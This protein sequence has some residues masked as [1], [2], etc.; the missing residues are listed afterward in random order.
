[1][2][3]SV[4]VL[5]V[6]A[7]TGYLF[8][9]N[10]RVNQTSTVSSD[11]A[12]L[13]E[14]RVKQ[15]N[16][17]QKEV[18]ALSNDVNTM[19]KLS[20]NDNEPN[21]KDDG[22]DSS[23][24]MPA[25]EGPGVTVTLDDSP[26]WKQAVD[27][28]GSSADI[29]KYVIHQQDIEAVINALWEGGAEYMKVMDQRVLFNSAVMCSGNVISLHGKKY[30][31]PF[32]ISAIGNPDDLIQA[33]DASPTIKIYKQYV[34]AFGLG[35]KVDRKK[36]LH[37]DQCAKLLQPLKYAKAVGGSQESESTDTNTAKGDDDQ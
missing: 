25:V 5:V 7:I 19:T 21:N 13:V 27:S 33:L 31:P 14:Q 26:M 11:T 1:M 37:F 10:L 32:T 9:T 30:S 16:T 4:A 20:T 18:N 8:V 36:N 28:S 23:T 15:V 17:L 29:D 3:G 2:V 35:W 24:V 22:G 12:G 6:V 34:S